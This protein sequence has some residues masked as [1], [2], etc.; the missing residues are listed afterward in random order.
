MFAFTKLLLLALDPANLLFFGFLAAVVLLR[1]SKLVW[2]LRGLAVFFLAVWVTPLTD[3]LLAPLEQRY[4]VPEQLPGRIDGVVVLGGWQDL[5]AARTHGVVAVNEASERLLIGAWLARQHPEARLVFSGGSGDPRFPELNESLV[6]RRAAALLG[7]GSEQVIYEETSRN[8]AENA[9]HS[10]QLVK[11]KPGEVWV[12]VTSASHLPRA[13]RCFEKVGWKVIPYPC[14]YAAAPGTWFR[15]G[16]IGDALRRLS[17]AA[18]EWVG[19]A[20]YALFGKV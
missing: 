2:V 17:R 11:P 14:D 6:N 9:A 13:M 19:M 5:L 16:S 20:V 18:R 12:L 8:T 10:Y 4:Q 15:D 7:L 1:R 3:A